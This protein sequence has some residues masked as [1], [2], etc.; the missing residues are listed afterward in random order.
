MTSKVQPAA[1]EPVTSKWRQKCSQL[2]IIEILTENT[3]GQDC[4][5]GEQKNK[6][7]NGKTPLRMGKYFVI[8]NSKAIE[9]SFRRIWRILQILDNTLGG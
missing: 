5:I 4:V 8:S 1:G 3:W 2:Q 9:F 6:E 7:R